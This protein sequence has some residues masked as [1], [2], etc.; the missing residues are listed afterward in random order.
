MKLGAGDLAKIEAT[1]RGIA[2]VIGPVFEQ[3]G[4]LFALLA[5][6]PGEHG[7]SSYISNAERTGL[8]L[9][10]REMA[11]K[12]EADQDMPPIEPGEPGAA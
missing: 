10:L 7:F 4:A 11:A 1:A 8:I 3:A 2:E 6:T 12:L 9:A 5:F